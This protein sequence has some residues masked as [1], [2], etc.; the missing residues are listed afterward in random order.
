MY[1]ILA[2]IDDAVIA[3]DS[4]EIITFMNYTA[5]QL[6]GWKQEDALEKDLKE[7]FKLADRQE[8][9]LVSDRIE[10]V[11]KKGKTEKLSNNRVLITRDGKKVPIE[12]NTTAVKDKTGIDKEIPQGT[13][14]VFRDISECNRI[15]ESE[16]ERLRLTAAVESVTSSIIITDIDGKIQY[17][18]PAFE[19]ITGYTRKEIIDRNSN[20]L[21]SGKQSKAFYRNMWDRLV[22]G[23]IWEGHLI[24]RK[25][26][27]TFYELDATISPVKSESGKIVSY[28][29]VRHDITK[30]VLLEKQ[31][32][33]AQKMEAIGTLAGGIAHD[34]NNILGIILG[35]TE[36]AISDYPEENEIQNRLKEVFK[37]ACRAK[38]LV[39]QILTFSRQE[40]Q[41]LI[42]IRVGP[43]IKEGLKLLR[44]SLPATIE[45]RN[46]INVKADTVMADPVQ[47][48]QV[49]MNLCIN[50]AQAMHGN[51]GILKV[52][53]TNINIDAPDRDYNSNL[54]PGLYLK[55]TVS[56]TG[57]GMEQ[58]IMDHIFEPYFTTKDRGEGTG[59]GLSVVHGIIKRIGGAINVSSN[60]G[61]GT[62]FEVFF[63]NERQR[64]SDNNEIS[65]KIFPGNERILFVDDEKALIKMGQKMLQKIGYKVTAR[66]SG[67][68]AIELFR[69]QKNKFDLVITDLTMPGITG[70]ELSKEILKIRPNI[71]IILCSGYGKMLSIEQL[72]SIGIRRFIMKPMAI[73]DIAGTIRKVLDK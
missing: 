51:N 19:R 47:I 48:H 13:V 20:I 54:H 66:T 46:K 27:G 21:N 59:L 23:K 36:M 5:E 62:T 10:R 8:Q 53:L 55:L 9:H 57:Y 4:S 61:K 68:A 52:N 33:Q 18:N 17:V 29:S 16:D 67:T 28:V 24:N 58:S 45:I 41:E 44:A 11:I 6:T 14:L 73:K 25:K 42:P 1:N 35:Y 65:T 3:A 22:N 69:R 34:F 63:P 39:R 38:N 64:T 50:A 32:R 43:I 31:L 71:P 2:G 15:R 60:I 72:K 56:D 12:L 7:V 40:E 26:D 37:A 30:E 70:I 49:L